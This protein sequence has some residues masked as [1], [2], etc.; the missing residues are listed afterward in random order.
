MNQLE[1]ITQEITDYIRYNGSPEGA[2]E[3]AKRIYNTINNLDPHTSQALQLAN[4]P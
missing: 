2:P 3:L 1:T 4:T